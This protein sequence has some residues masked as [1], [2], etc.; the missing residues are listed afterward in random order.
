MIGKR[1]PIDRRWLPLNALRAFEAVGQNLSFTA[2]AQALSVSQSAMSRHVSGLEALIGKSL[3]DRSSIGLKLTPA[4]EALLPVISKCLDRIEQTINMVRTDSGGG[5]PIRTHMP[6]SLLYQVGLSLIQNFHRQHPETP[7][8]VFSSHVTG[9]PPTTVDMAIVYDRP[10]TDDKVTD[11][12][13]M[14]R[15]APLCSPE[16]FSGHEGKTLE[17]F[18]ASNELL[19]IKLE[20]EP[21]SM[22]WNG[23][24]DQHRLSIETDRGLAFDTSISAVRYAMSAPGIV[25]AD[26]DMF[27]G[28]IA[29][30]K[31][32]M[33]YNCIWKTGF[34]YYLKTHV[35]D[36]S[37]PS[38][39]IFRDWIIRHFAKE[40]NS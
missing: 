17:E 4:G 26:V 11:L 1:G 19:H 8:D 25:L 2:G 22:L 29:S 15:V 28:D 20:G 16:T 34:G 7:I 32:L 9:L 37:D 27:S 31:I 30:G 24:A 33:P 13:W 40:M 35:E 38:V 39:L 21:R 3:F 23:F 6:P 12:L 36:L 10:H 14:E 5:S 18:V